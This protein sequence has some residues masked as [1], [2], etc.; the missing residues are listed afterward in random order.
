LAPGATSTRR[1]AGHEKL[2]D[3][4][5][6]FSGTARDYSTML[7]AACKVP[8]SH[9][10][11]YPVNTRHAG[12]EEDFAQTGKLAEQDAATIASNEKNARTPRAPLCKI[13]CRVDLL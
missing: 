2:K 1:V 8:T 5:K 11:A 10:P 13:Y 9:S 12:M 7:S 3:H 4:K 6:L